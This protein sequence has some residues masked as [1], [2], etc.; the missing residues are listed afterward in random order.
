[1]LRKRLL[2]SLFMIA[3]L[4]VFLWL[5]TN[6]T[7]NF[8]FPGFW[9]VPIILAFGLAVAGELVA[10]LRE[11]TPGAAPWVVYLGVVFCHAGVIAPEILGLPE[12]GPLVRIGCC[13][14]GLIAALAGAFLYELRNFHPDHHAT[15]KLALTLFVTLYA[16]WTLS[17]LSAMRVSLE[18]HKGIVALFSVLFIIK[19]S[20]AGA[21]FAGKQFGRH[22]LAPVLSP[23]KTME[24]LVGGFI[25]AV[26]A[27]GIIFYA[28]MP[29][30]VSGY[31]AAWPAVLGYAFSL[32]AVGVIGDLSE[33]LIK[34]DMHR[35]DSS[36]WLPGLGGIMDTADSVI[37]NAPVAFL[38]WSSGLL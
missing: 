33:S 14:V 4:L 22:K 8:G 32:A 1:M 21:Y 23:G 38:W 9:V 31:S 29:Q 26:L 19:L 16:G 2:A 12:R 25:A 7:T 10:M 5:D 36:Q 18:N 3:P 11:R 6:D 20:D 34:R 30:V 28:V 27:S 17:F 35:K 13:G 37:L 15:T 24:G